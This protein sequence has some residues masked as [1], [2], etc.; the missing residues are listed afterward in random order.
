MAYTGTVATDKVLDF[1]GGMGHGRG[2]VFEMTS[3][4]GG[5]SACVPL[6]GCNCFFGG[7]PCFRGSLTLHTQVEAFAFLQD[8]VA[9]QEK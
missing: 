3:W 2:L 9:D 6:G 4:L 7:R 1:F 5:H 8:N